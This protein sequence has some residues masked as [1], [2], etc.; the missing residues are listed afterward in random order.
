MTPRPKSTKPPKTTLIAVRVP[1]E[2]YADL[3]AVQDRD[4]VPVSEQLRRGIRLWLESKGVMKA[5]RKRADTR[6]RS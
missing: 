5:E 4:G 2:T 6:R 1:D 3:K